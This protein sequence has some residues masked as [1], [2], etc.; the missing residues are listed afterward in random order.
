M[1][2]TTLHTYF[3]YTDAPAAL[4]WLERAFGFETTIEAADDKGGIMHAELRRGDI[5]I[6]VFSDDAGRDR[7]EVKGE[8]V[9]HGT[10][11]GVASEGEVDAVF[12][13]AVK[14]GATPIW[15]PEA[16]KWGNY[17]CRV[18]DLEGYEWTFGIYRP[19]LTGE[20]VQD[21]G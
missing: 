3:S 17:R 5:A 14:E 9:G 11:V 12:A 10:Y 2:S 21:Q 7:I 4:R 18:L 6:I 13:D 19:G 8:T 20:E 16:T 1:T 15:K